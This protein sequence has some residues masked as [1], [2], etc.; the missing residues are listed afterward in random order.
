MK[1]DRQ[2]SQLLV[3]NGVYMEPGPD[4]DAVIRLNNELKNESARGVVLIATAMI[5]EQLREVLLATL[6]PN[7]SSSDTLFDGPNS[8]FGSLSSK[9]DVAYR[10]GIISDK[11]CRDLHIVRRIRNDVAHQPQSFRFED[12]SPKNRIETLGKSHGIF[13]RSPK[14]VEK[15]GYPSLR[16]QFLE[17]ASWMLFFLAAER[18]RRPTLS[19]RTPE[20]GYVMTHDEEQGLRPDFGT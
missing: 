8:P 16:S 19:M 17:A 14:W 2:Q 6:V 7:P 9:I 13:E 12:P 5:E 20:F 1:Q 4:F 18:V 10:L 11:L 15:N 3:N